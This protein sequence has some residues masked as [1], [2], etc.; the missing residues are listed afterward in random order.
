VSTFGI[1]EVSLHQL[2]A[3]IRPAVPI[4]PTPATIITS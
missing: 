1:C 4:R 3:T 2:R